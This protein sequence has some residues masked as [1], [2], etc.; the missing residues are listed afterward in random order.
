MEDSPRAAPLRLL[1]AWHTTSMS[2]R[3]RGNPASTRFHACGLW[4]AV[5]LEVEPQ[6]RQN[7]CFARACA[8]RRFHA[9]LYPRLVDDSE[10]RG[11][12]VRRCLFS[13]L[14]LSREQSTQRA[15]FFVRCPHSIHGTG[16][17]GICSSPP[18]EMTNAP[19]HSMSVEA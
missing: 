4:S 9:L 6:S 1:H 11:L 14:Y 7:G 15:P 19:G 13:R 18:L 3:R 8:L 16:K 10:V 2:C 12:S 5:R 17:G